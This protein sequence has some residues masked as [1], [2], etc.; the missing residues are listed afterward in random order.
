MGLLRGEA[1]HLPPAPGRTPELLRTGRGAGPGG[2]EPAA[3]GEGEQRRG[4]SAQLP[5]HRADHAGGPG[6]WEPGRGLPSEPPVCI[7][8]APT[9]SSLAPDTPRHH[10]RGRAAARAPPRPVPE[11]AS[12][13][14]GTTAEPH[15]PAPGLSFTQGASHAAHAGRASGE[16]AGHPC[17]RAR[18]GLNPVCPAPSHPALTLILSWMGTPGELA[19]QKKGMRSHLEPCLSR[20]AAPTS[21]GGLLERQVWGPTPIY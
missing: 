2:S 8:S 5:R 17:P 21:P 4:H 1:S 9:S 16:W 20:S 18:P 12:R 13:A 14:C 3:G 15:V 7:L 19:F 10:L 11:E 6:S